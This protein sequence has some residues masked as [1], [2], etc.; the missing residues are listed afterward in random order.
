MKHCT[1]EWFT[2]ICTLYSHFTAWHTSDVKQMHLEHK[3]H[4]ASALH[5]LHIRERFHKELQSYPHP[6][7]LLRVIDECVYIVGIF[8]QVMTIPQIYTIWIDHNA[9]GVNPWTWW[10]Y[11]AQATVWFVYGI[12]HKA[13]P[14]MVTYFVWII[15]NTLVALGAFIY[16]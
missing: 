10:S 4:I 5:H 12:V 6:K 13:K 2:I 3:H 9:G 1:V 8:G 11:V 14:I 15:M 16:G 7:K